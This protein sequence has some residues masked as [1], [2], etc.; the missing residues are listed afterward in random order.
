MPDTAAQAPTDRTRVRRIA[1]NAHYDRATLHAIIDAAYLC[2]LAFADEKGTHCIPMAC[3]REGE[4][5][6]IHGSNGGRLLKLLQK[7]TQACV[8]ITHLDGLVLARSAFN[9][10]MNYRSAMV[11]GV[12][13]RVEDKRAALDAFMQHLAPGRQHE[14]RPG[15]DKEFAATTVMRISLDEAACKVRS[16]GPVDDEEDMAHPAWA[17]VLPFVVMHTPPVVDPV[18]GIAPPAYVQGWTRGG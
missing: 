13:E 17:G 4:Y 1:E 2:H 3:W 8:T 12:F 16:G 5:L 7:G 14:A 11:Y 9:H 6:Y 10:S 15:S 18:C